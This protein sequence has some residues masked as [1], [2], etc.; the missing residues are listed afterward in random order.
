MKALR[1][2][3]ESRE[4]FIQL[5]ALHPV[6]SKPFRWVLLHKSISGEGKKKQTGIQQRVCVCVFSRVCFRAGY[7]G[8]W[9]ITAEP[10]GHR[11]NALIGR[12]GVCLFLREGD[13]GQAG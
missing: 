7:S 12:P 13:G 4:M 10:S 5:N 2:C 1:W 11:S 9:S 6:L 8:G 3:D